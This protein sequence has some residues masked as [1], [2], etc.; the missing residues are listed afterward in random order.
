MLF[1]FRWRA[2]LIPWLVAVFAAP[3]AL[4]SIGE[5]LTQHLYS[6]PFVPSTDLAFVAPLL[7]MRLFTEE[8]RSG[9]LELLMTAPVS[10]LQ[11]VA[12]KFGGALCTFVVFLTPLWII[13]LLLATVF[14]ASPDWGQLLALT[15]QQSKHSRSPSMDQLHTTLTE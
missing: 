2:R 14:G 13:S 9:S 10:D 15:K 11:V 7:T 4:F 8:K 5:G 3:V 6:Q 1:L 12:A